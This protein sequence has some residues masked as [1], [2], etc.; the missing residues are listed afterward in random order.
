MLVFWNKEFDK[1]VSEAPNPP[2]QVVEFEMDD[3]E[4]FAVTSGP[5]TYSESA[6]KLVADETVIASN[7]R[8]QRSALLKDSDW[9]QL[10]DCPLD[11]SELSEWAAYRQ[12][13]R[14]ITD[15]PGFP[16]EVVW[17]TPPAS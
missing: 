10:A 17:P 13:L 15:Q 1:D 7:V 5:H 14:D 4:Y 6:G 9:T 16:M 2:R 12:A 8:A 3:D 11:E